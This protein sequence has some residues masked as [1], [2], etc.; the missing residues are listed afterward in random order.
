[1]SWSDD[2]RWRRRREVHYDGRVMACF[3]ERAVNVDAM[4]RATLARHGDR[5]ALVLGPARVNYAELDALVERVAGNLAR[6]GVDKGERVAV[7]LG[8]R[9][10]FVHLV[11]ACARLGAIVVPL[12]VRQKGPE[13]E[14]ALN[15]SGAR[16]LVHEAELA[17][18]IPAAARVP[19]LKQRFA[20]GGEAAGSRPFD[21]LLGPGQA[22]PRA[23]AEEDTAC[24]LYTSGTTG[25]P[26][27]A[28]LTHLG[29]VHSALHFELCMGLDE[30]DRTILAVPASHVT[31]LVAVILAMVGVGGCTIMMPA[32]KARAFLELATREGLTQSVMVPTMYNL[33]L[34]E[35][36]FDDHDLSAW[37]VGGYGGAPM[38]TATIDALAAR[39]PRLVLQNA[40]GATETT[41]PTTVM[42]PGETLGHE[43]SVGQTVP[44]GEVSIMDEEGR[45]VAPGEPGEIWIAGPMV[46]PG[47]WRNAEAT[48]ANFVGGFWRSG[49]IGGRDGEGFLRVLDRIKDMINRAG[50]KV[51][52]AE[53][54]NLLSHHP[55]VVECAVVASPD[56]VLGERV[57]AFVVPAAAPP[58]AAQVTA[59]C[60]QSLSDYKVPEFF[61][62]LDQPLPRNAN[63]KVVKSVL[64]EQA[65]RLAAAEIC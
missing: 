49:D 47:Y 63:G 18:E 12:N 25:R 38:P 20:C 55:A 16:V 5:E 44:C 54:E 21:E 36:D 61:T 37:R 59:Y 4:F 42:P 19:A 23:I 17:H 51:Y 9:L 48:D 2:G 35:P 1:M 43:D 52:S 27:G 11:L 24:I 7:L 65:E 33:C 31:G 56:A 39:Q 14:F 46:V 26:K 28:M 15:D 50:Y 6:H 34:L 8:N 29:L 58:S 32:F 41:S 45:E 3:A 10:E 60:D 13:I 30:R 57:H 22:P 62:F 64:R 40:Y 53:V